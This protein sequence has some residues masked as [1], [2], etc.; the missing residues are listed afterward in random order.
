MQEKKQNFK[1]I[2]NNKHVIIKF[3][4]QIKEA[5]KCLIK[6]LDLK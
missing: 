5:N 1:V 4:K 3:T 2:N 6:V